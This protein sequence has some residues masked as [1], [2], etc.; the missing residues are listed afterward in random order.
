MPPLRK[1]DS[2]GKPRQK[3][4]PGAGKALTDLV[5]SI[6]ALV[7]MNGTIQILVYPRLN[8]ALGTEA[9]GDMLFLVGL[10][11][12]FGAGIGCAM[13]N[14]RLLRQRHESAGN[15]D[16][17]L[18]LLSYALPACLAVGA[19][20]WRVLTPAQAVL[21][22]VLTLAIT[23][24]YY[25]DVEYRLSLNYKRYFVYYALLSAGYLAGVLLWETVPS[26]LFVLLLGECA[27]VC[28]C[29]VTGGIYHPMTGSRR[30]A[31]IERCTAQ[32]MLSY[33]LYNA[34]VQMDRVLLRVA[35]D[36]SAVTVF[37]VA[38]ILGKVIALLVGPLNAVLVS[39]L[40]RWERRL[41]SRLTLLF[42][43]G[44]VLCTGLFY[45]AISLVTPFVVRWLYPDLCTQVLQYAPIANL[46]QILCF[47]GSLELT[48][49]LTLAPAR[50]QLA[51]QGGYA[52][53]FMAG[54]LAGVQAAG[55]SGF[56]WATAAAGALRF[57]VAFALLL[58]YARREKTTA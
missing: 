50:W 45:L 52:L 29:M 37:Y 56:V 18:S 44:I 49:L 43:G 31:D 48:L 28:F 42:T 36:S 54:G 21:A 15:L 4:L 9:Y 11:T 10:A 7:L 39:Y 17:L 55:L 12:I 33:L 26:W 5:W 20:A 47:A 13:N 1:P 19:V 6:A 8:R 34:V 14:G 58:Y 32:L 27:C 16:Y 23:L 25:S 40:T 2:A 30:F 41:D 3:T 46:G 22:A 57:A 53:V 38:S 51:V 35:M 24:R